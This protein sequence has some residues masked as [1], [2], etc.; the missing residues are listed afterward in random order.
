MTTL[1]AIFLGAVQGLTEF[2]PVSS[3]GHLKI[4]EHLFGFQKLDDY[5]L[6]D[7]TCH[8]GTLLALL[9]LTFDEIKS[10]LKDPLKCK[11]LALGT[12]PLFPCALFLGP[13]KALMTEPKFLGASFLATSLALFLG[14]RQRA[15]ASNHLQRDSL[16]IG[17]SQACALIPGLSRSGMTISSARFL[18]WER[19]EATKFSFLLAIPA[20]L[21]GVVLEGA[22]VLK[23]G[24]FP[25]GIIPLTA[26]FFSA[27]FFG[28]LTLKAFLLL[29]RRSG[30][31]G[32]ALYCFLLGFF[33]LFK[34]M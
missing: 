1:Q 33:L 15:R 19:E 25:I 7:L 16:V 17:L 2:F 23:G 31:L 22:T 34:G 11:L 30:F 9:W 18:G 26:G 20:I 29:T 13:I 32:F 10:S 4:F 21:G 3:S 24:S 5:L 27:F 6:F 28:T 8:F 14:E 12:L